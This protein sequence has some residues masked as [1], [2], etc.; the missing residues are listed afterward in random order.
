MGRLIGRHISGSFCTIVE[1]LLLHRMCRALVSIIRSFLQQQQQPPHN[2]SLPPAVPP[3]PSGLSCCCCSARAPQYCGWKKKEAIPSRVWVA[4]ADGDKCLQLVPM[5]WLVTLLSPT[6]PLSDPW[7][8]HPKYII[9]A[10]QLFFRARCLQAH[11]LQNTVP[12]DLCA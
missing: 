2:P 6:S 7:W 1:L 10:T 5:Y 4:V 8:T 12:E 11:W 9:L 3:T